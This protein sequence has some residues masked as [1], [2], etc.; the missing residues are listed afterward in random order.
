MRGL[1]LLQVHT[2]SSTMGDLTSASKGYCNEFIYLFLLQ[3]PQMEFLPF[4]SVLCWT[5]QA[6]ECHVMDLAVMCI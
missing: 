4:I 2:M 6:T 3:Q 1:S 5:V